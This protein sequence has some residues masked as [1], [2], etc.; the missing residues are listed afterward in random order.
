MKRDFF[1]GNWGMESEDVTST[2]VEI[3]H[4]TTIGFD[5]ADDGGGG[6]GGADT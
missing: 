3:G 2:M 4:L 1:I 6:D 5:D